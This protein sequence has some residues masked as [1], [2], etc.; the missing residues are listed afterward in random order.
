MPEEKKDWRS[1]GDGTLSQEDIDKLLSPGEDESLSDRE[2]SGLYNPMYDTGSP[3]VYSLLKAD[4][5]TLEQIA[6]I[7]SA[8]ASFAYRA[9]AYLRRRLGIE[10]RI[11]NEST[12]ELTLEEFVVSLAKP[13]PLLEIKALGLG[14]SI[15][16]S[17]APGIALGL[18]DA[19]LGGTGTLPPDERALTPLENKLLEQLTL[20]LMPILRQA[21]GFHIDLD[22]R[23]PTMLPLDDAYT[24]A[25]PAE[26]TVLTVMSMRLGKYG[27]EYLDEQFCICMPR[28]LLRP[29]F[30]LLSNKDILR[31]RNEQTREQSAGKTKKA[32][33]K[34]DN[35]TF[36]HVRLHGDFSVAHGPLS[37]GELRE[38]GPGSVIPLPRD[39]SS[40]T[41]FDFETRREQ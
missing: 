33:L 28:F 15:L 32:H 34:E 9:D 14:G 40:R 25:E 26:T 36:P 8:N 12:N 2:A 38:L 23:P 39:A 13:T 7:N 30:P 19:M 16:M 20:E 21:W 10:C 27:G 5:T 18:V 41:F 29:L 37:N 31:R 24:I 17:F 6:A 11:F 22:P 1:S 35:P 4:T 3:R